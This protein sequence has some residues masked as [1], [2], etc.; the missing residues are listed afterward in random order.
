MLGIL[1]A[2]NREQRGMKQKSRAL[3]EHFE[4]TEDDSRGLVRLPGVNGD[5]LRRTN[6]PVVERLHKL[7]HYSRETPKK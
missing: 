2:A 1:K 3:P 6:N 7:H 4:E 5:P